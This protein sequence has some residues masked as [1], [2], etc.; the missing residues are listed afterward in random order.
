MNTVKPAY[1]ST[2]VIGAIATILVAIA[3][4]AHITVTPENMPIVMALAT[5]IG[6]GF[7]AL[8]GRLKATS[9]I[10]KAVSACAQLTECLQPGSIQVVGE[11]G[12]EMATVQPAVTPAAPPAPDRMTDTLA[13]LLAAVEKMAMQNVPAFGVAQNMVDQALPGPGADAAPAAA[14]VAQPAATQAAGA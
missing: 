6:F 1:K 5:I 3:A 11:K 13:A 12:P 10:G 8:V 4:M 7:M 14:S 9:I 2:G